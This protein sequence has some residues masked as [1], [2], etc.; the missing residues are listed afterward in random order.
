[1]IETIDPFGNSNVY[2]YDGQN[3]LIARTDANHNTSHFGYN[4]QFSLTGQTNGNGD[5]TTFA[6]Y[7]NGNLQSRTDSGGTTSYGY[8]SY[9]ALGSVT[10]AG[11]AG[12]DS[13]QN[14][15]YGDPTNHTNP[16]TF[17]T[18][19]QY[20]KRRQ[21]TNT[22]GPSNVTTSVSYDAVG[23][24]QTSTDA[25]QNV[26]TYFWSPTRH[27]TGAV[28]P[29]TP[30]GTPFTTN[31]YDNRD[32]LQLKSNAAQQASYYSNNAAQQ[33]IS[34]ADALLRTNT[35]TYDADG[36]QKTSADPASE[37]TTQV[38]D[39]RGDLTR[40][41]DATQKVIGRAYDTAGNMIFLTN[42]NTNVWT[43]Q[44][45]KA[46][47]LTNTIS[48]SNNTTSEVYNNRGL[49]FT[50]TDAKH[51]TTTFSYDAKGR[52]TNRSDSIG[53]IGYQYDGDDNQTAVTNVGQGS[54]LSWVYDA[55][56][57]PVSCTDANGNLIQYRYDANGNLT[58]LIYPGNLPV[59][60]YYDNLNRVTNITDWAGRQT[61]NIYDLAGELTNILR[62]NGTMRSVTYDT[63]GQVTNIVERYVN[64]AMAIGYFAL[65]WN[66]AGRVQWEFAAPLPHTCTPPSRTMTYDG[67]NR[68]ATFN[69]SNIGVDNDGNMTS[70]PGTNNTFLSY[71]YN[72]RNQLT[73]AGA[74][75]YGYD[76]AGNR[77]SATNGST[78]TTYVV[79]PKSSQV[80]MRMRPGMT[81][82]YIYGAGLLYEI[83]VTANSTNT[84]YYHYDYR[85][86]T[87]AL[88][89]GS[90]NV[91]DRVEYS[92]YGLTTY[93][94][95]TNDTPFL[96][97]G[98]YGVQTDP[99][100][101]LFMRAR[102]Y[103]PY[104][105]RFLNADPNGFAGGLNFYAFADENPISEMDPFGLN[106]WTSVFG[107]L[108]VVGGGL[109]AAAG[110]TLGAATSW[111]GIG[112][113]GGGLVALHGADQVQAGLRQ[114]FTG[115]QA[116][117]LTS[118]GLQAAGMSPTAANLTDAGISVVGSFGAGLGTTAIRAQSVISAETAN[119]NVV[120]QAAYYEIGQNTVSD[121]ANTFYSLWA[122]PIDRGA[123]KV[124]D[125]GWG[126]AW[127][128]GYGYTLGI[129]KTFMTG[130]TPIG[131]AGA[132]SVLTGT[133][134]AYNSSTGK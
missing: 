134:A 89:D 107:G 127:P 78:V 72:A 69:G 101:L 80:L 119:A 66:N 124:A 126:V 79:D 64:G 130:P 62:P 125:Q 70:G 12:I 81:N 58:N 87:V 43:F 106:G 109:E 42:R 73:S 45:D 59:K 37:T 104:I 1:L 98:L 110:I 99:N 118:Q 31:T 132:A 57:R 117:S 128:Q 74:L 14:N 83:D 21:L 131:T 33:L 71:A 95:G 113:I 23:N 5:W 39:G 86:S 114:L 56:D 26:M 94:L 15:I 61:T 108:R 20:N 90:G 19:F 35:F 34:L 29:S 97:N 27:Q 11:G 75:G 24:V 103:N 63:G 22:I 105:S 36:R 52:M 91:T 50:V 17:S 30:Q 112:A 46:N 77:T 32:W 25:R 111:T 54:G 84:A 123:A 65:N 60:Y 67:E 133:A 55:Y 10:N 38:W 41:I 44:Y 28:F 102:Y 49:L 120:R 13:Y 92:A 68:L 100:G 7:G 96:F 48:P 2:V 51:Q 18:A 129:G 3:N 82:Y 122:N 16:R 76:P 121:D 53:N 115:N 93:R 9:G 85:G 4:N 40:T 116:N 8:D 47:R 88:T 6:Y